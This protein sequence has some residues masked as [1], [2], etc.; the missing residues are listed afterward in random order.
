MTN[1][2]DDTVSPL[3]TVVVPTYKRPEML[4]GA[5]RS[6]LAQTLPDF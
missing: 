3:V 6:A 1:R 5:L 2:L 4:L